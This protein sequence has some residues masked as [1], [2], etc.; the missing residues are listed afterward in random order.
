MI[1]Q[2]KIINTS[3]F[4]KSNTKDDFNKRLLLK[5]ISAVGG[6]IVGRA[7]GTFGAPLPLPVA[8]AFAGGT[9]GAGITY[10][11]HEKTKKARCL[12]KH[13]CIENPYLIRSLR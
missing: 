2:H 9:I 13:H 12:A 5:G 6:P 11:L 3:I 8:S 10:V 1:L 7:I 4:I